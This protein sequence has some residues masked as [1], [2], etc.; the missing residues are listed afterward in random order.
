MTKNEFMTYMD[1]LN[2]LFKFDMPDKE[3]LPAW[4]KPFERT[5]LYIAQKMADMYFQEEQGRFKLSKLIEYK[6]KAM[7]G[8]IYKTEKEERCPI[9]DNTG[10]VQVEVPY[11]HTYTI[12]CKRCICEI[13]ESIPKYVRQ[14]TEEELK[15]IDHNGRI[16]RNLTLHHND[17]DDL[18]ESSLDS[19][20]ERMKGSAAI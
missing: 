9:C 1:Y 15:G 20:F 5:N 13:G 18:P 14:V 7:A 8:R 6:S 3:V 11:R 12:Q 2:K 17:D 19:F 10:Y 16:I 4:Y